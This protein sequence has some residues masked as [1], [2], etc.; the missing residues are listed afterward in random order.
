VGLHTRRTRRAEQQ[1]AA[2][3]ELFYDLVF[4][5]AVTQVSHLLLGN[6]TWGGAVDALVALLVVWWAWD[7]T[8]WVTS[9]V[10]P[11]QTSVRLLLLAMM[12][13][14]L[15]MAVAVPEAFGR[16]GLL[17]ACSYVA[18]KVGRLAFLTFDTSAAG[19]VRAPGRGRRLLIWFAVSGVLWIAGGLA[20]GS[21]RTGIW[22][23]ALALDLTGPMVMYWVPRRGRLPFGAWTPKTS[24]FVERF[25]L[26][27]II[28]FGETIVLTGAATSELDLDLARFVGLTLAFVGTAAMWWLYFD[29][30]PRIA[31]RRLELAANPIQLARDAYMYLHVVLVA[32][33]LL[34]AVGGE[35]VIEH[36]TR[37]L[38]DAEVAV[39]AAGPALY[40]LGHVLVRLRLT[41]WVSWE[42][43]GGAAACV[44]VGLIGTTVPGLALAALLVSVLVGVI[45]IEHVAV[46]R[47]RARGAPSPFEQLE[48]PAVAST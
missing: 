10:D 36:P 15:V 19:T 26:F 43:L 27:M 3:L 34:A 47:R 7:Y 12:L 11:E 21:T 31:K 40:L 28:A 48:E 32:G 35:L 23:A 18:I 25:G 29:D 1:E 4:V 14:S 46:A 37:V 44:V 45:A 38:S 20:D 30:F 42:R 24:H 6:L 22:I 5:F 8:T 41:G 13:A 2:P 33:V 39:R 9:E 16:H 17:F